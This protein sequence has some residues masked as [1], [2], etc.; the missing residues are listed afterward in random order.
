MI[1]KV[2]YPG[3]PIWE[4]LWEKAGGVKPRREGKALVGPSYW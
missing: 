3:R 4:K 1:L 2:D